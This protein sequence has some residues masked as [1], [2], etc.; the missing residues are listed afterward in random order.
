MKPNRSIKNLLTFV[1]LQFAIFNAFGQECGINGSYNWDQI[2]IKV[3]DPASPLE[4]EM[5]SGEWKI[6][7]HQ[8]IADV[9]ELSEDE[10]TILRKKVAQ[11]KACALYIDIYGVM[12]SSEGVFYYGV[13][14]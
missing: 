4:Q 2:S 14:E 6:E 12:N 8:S 11:S 1:V 3:V 9:S 10:L 13:Y 5:I 7:G